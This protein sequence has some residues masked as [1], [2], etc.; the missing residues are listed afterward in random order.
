MG[1]CIPIRSLVIAS[2]N[3]A[4]LPHFI[5]TGTYSVSDTTPTLSPSMDISVSSNFER[6]LFDIW[7]RDAAKTAQK[8]AEL[9]AQ[10]SFTVTPVELAVARTQFSA[11]SINETQTLD[12]IRSVFTSDNYVLC[13][14]S[15]VGYCAAQQFRSQPIF[16]GEDIVVLATAH[17]GK[18]VEGVCSSLG[19]S[20]D[21]GVLRDALQGCIPGELRALVELSEQGGHRR[22]DIANDLEAV[23]D[24]MRK[25]MKCS[26]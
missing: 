19:S 21:D 3:N 16:D 24:Y 2:N 5:S 17:M 14:H 1:S 8:F 9:S 7:G 15:A 10:K 4:I 20:S 18:F 23:K 26:V 22:T 25:H 12:T 11:F 6:F 13:P